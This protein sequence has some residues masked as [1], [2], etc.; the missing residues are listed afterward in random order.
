LVVGRLQHRLS[1]PDE[2]PLIAIKGKYHPNE[3]A[4][5]PEHELQLMPTIEKNDGAQS[6]NKKETDFANAAKQMTD[7][8]I[9]PES[10]VR[11][12]AICEPITDL[13]NHNGH[14]GQHIIFG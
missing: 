6:G 12:K 7:Q 11:L 8:D 3:H 10:Q 13:H 2:L 4:G 1:E 9:P 5:L 14:E